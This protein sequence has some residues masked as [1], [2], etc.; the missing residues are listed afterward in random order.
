M[1]LTHWI[2]RAAALAL[3]CLPF[4]TACDEGEDGGDGG[5]HGDGDEES[6]VITTVTLTFT[7]I[8]GGSA[9]TATFDDPDGNGIMA[10]TI[11]DIGLT[12]GETYEFSIELSNALEDPAED[13]T[14]EIREESEEHQFFIYGSGVNGPASTGG[15]TL[16]DH[17]YA[18]VESDYGPNADGDDLP[19][20]LINTITANAAGNA[21]FTVMLRHLPSLNGTAQKLPGLAADFAAG[22]AL[23]GEPDVDITFPLTV[24]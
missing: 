12:S 18:D 1:K 20:G 17:A 7:P 2:H 10:P 19:V 8:S 21:E 23:P 13:I 11:D 16:A 4:T 3:L 6:E 14:E 24:Q 9:V 15:A 5:V 22:E